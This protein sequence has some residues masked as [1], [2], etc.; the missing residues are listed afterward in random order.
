MLINNNKSSHLTAWFASG[1][2]V[3]DRRREQGVLQN[4]YMSRGL[5]VMNT[6]HSSRA[7]LSFALTGSSRKV[8]L[9]F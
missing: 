5:Q 4:K 3:V 7:I 6:H 8:V 1:G 2:G 9:Q